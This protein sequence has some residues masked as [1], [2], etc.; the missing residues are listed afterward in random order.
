MNP[1]EE[2]GES[3]GG[4]LNTVERSEVT[5]MVYRTLPELPDIEA[6]SYIGVHF[7]EGASTLESFGLK[8]KLQEP[9]SFVSIA[10]INAPQLRQYDLTLENCLQLNIYSTSSSN[11][12]TGSSE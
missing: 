5:R 11:S 2:L 6:S 8:Y 10:V 12:F 1:S 9:L 7:D 3:S 4:P